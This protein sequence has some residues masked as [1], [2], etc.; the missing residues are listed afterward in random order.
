MS[1]TVTGLCPEQRPVGSW[2]TAGRGEGSNRQDTPLLFCSAFFAKLARAAVFRH[3]YCERSGS[4]SLAVLPACPVTSEAQ[5]DFLEER[6]SITES[7]I[8]RGDSAI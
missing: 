2:G 6:M 8:E 1:Q 5:T 7:R 3:A 4:V